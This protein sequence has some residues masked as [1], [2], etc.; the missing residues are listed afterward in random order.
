MPRN[1]SQ[2]EL[3][4]EL[5]LRERLHRYA[6]TIDWLTD[7]LK[8]TTAAL[9]NAE[10]NLEEH[11]MTHTKDVSLLPYGTPMSSYTQIT[12]PQRVFQTIEE[13]QSDL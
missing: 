3:T 8:E 7:E 12:I 11:P 10:N 5:D 9:L 1:K 2:W 4:I 6:K 13:S